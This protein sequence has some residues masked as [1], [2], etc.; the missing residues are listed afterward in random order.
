MKKL[1]LLLAIVML[2]GC[3][4]AFAEEGERQFFNGNTTTELVDP[5]TFTKPYEVNEVIVEADETTGQV[6]LEAHI[7]GIIEVDGLKFK[8]LNANGELDPYEDWRLTSEERAKNLLSLMD[9]DEKIGLL[10]HASTGG[11]FTS[12]YP[13]TEQWLYSNEPTYTD[14]DGAC[15]VPMYHSIISDHVTTYLHNVNGTPDTLIYEN[16]AFQEIAESATPSARCATS[17]TWTRSRIPVPTWRT[18]WKW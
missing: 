17:S 11:T 12:M 3:V 9:E 4:S 15:Y 13:Y 18:C 5:T 10:W 6:R 2:M 14:Q 8:D 7:K 1:S 16:N